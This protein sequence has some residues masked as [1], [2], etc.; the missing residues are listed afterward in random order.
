MKVVS[1]NGFKHEERKEIV[2]KWRIFFEKILSLMESDFESVSFVLFL[3]EPGEHLPLENIYCFNL[4]ADELIGFIE[5]GKFS[6]LRGN[7]Y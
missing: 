3:R 5:R 1:L 2:D 4:D 6:F 7:T